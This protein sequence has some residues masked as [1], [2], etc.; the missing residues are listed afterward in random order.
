M[1]WFERYSYLDFFRLIA[2][3]LLVLLGACKQDGAI[4]IKSEDEFSQFR[5]S[6]SVQDTTEGGVVPIV[7]RLNRPSPKA[8]SFR[9]RAF[10]SS[11]T[12]NVDFRPIDQ[13]GTI[14]D[15]LRDR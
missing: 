7:V 2:I 5:L 1:K 8:V 14:A 3:G 6:F 15:L 4:E 12:A 13:I 10:S 11:A 9:V